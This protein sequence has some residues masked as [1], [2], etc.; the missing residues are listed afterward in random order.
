MPGF[1]RACFFLRSC[2]GSEPYTHTV[3]TPIRRI[4]LPLS[5]ADL[6]AAVRSAGED[7]DVRVILLES[8]GQ[9][10]C[11][12]IPDAPPELFQERFAKPI[13]AAVQGPALAEGVALLA[14]ADVVVAAQG[15]SFALTEIREGRWP[16]GMDAIAR[17]I[18]ARRARELALTGRVF[19]APE[20]L[21]YGLIHHLAP[22]FEFD[23]RA[24]AIASQ[25]AAAPPGA[26]R[27]ILS[28]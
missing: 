25:L 9:L 8:A 24:E 10:F 16:I 7:P 6:L 23:E 17:A 2:L 3:T 5:G 18:G 27:R 4:A 12:A 13:V 14:C 20:A 11:A 19:T 22:A 15:V 28:A 21:Q 1:G 26:V